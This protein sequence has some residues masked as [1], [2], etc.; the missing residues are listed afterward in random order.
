MAAVQLAG[1][2]GAE[3]YATASE[4]KW[5]V[6]RGLG[7]PEGRIASS[8]SLEFGTRFPKVDVVLN[9]LAREFTDASLD[10]MS[11]GGRFVELGK[12]DIRAADDIAARWPDVTY[13]AIDLGDAGPERLQEM[14]AELLSLF[15]RGV[16]SPLPVTAWDVRRA[17]EAFRYVGQARHVGKVVLTVPGSVVGGTVLVTGGTGLVGS[18]VARHLVAVHGVRRLVLASRQG[19]DA[20]GAAELAALG[21]DVRVVAC[22][23]SDRAALAGLLEGIPDLCGVV[24]AAGVLD[25]GVVTELSAERL[26]V[27]FRPKVDAVWHL[28]ELTKDRDLG[29]FVV[30]SS[31]AGVFGAPGQGNYSAANAFL[32]ALA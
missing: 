8:R 3:V 24:H 29:L 11:R 4:S 17:P 12:T 22:D 15:E 26:D 32:D 9:S 6:V 18:L 7:V 27:V 2:L 16:L 21:V 13:G 5:P 20:P 23:V 14:L 19:V 10:L 1:Y 31:A 25:D 28:H 30:F